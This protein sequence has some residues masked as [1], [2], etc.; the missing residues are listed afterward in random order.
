MSPPRE[1]TFLGDLLSSLTRR[2][3]AI[4]RRVRTLRFER[5]SDAID[6]SELAKVEIECDLLASRTVLRLNA[7]DDRWVWFDARRSSKTGWVWQFTAE[8]R[9]LGNQLTRELVAAFEASIGAQGSE[10]DL[11][12]IWAPILARGPRRVA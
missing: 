4:R 6:G 11:R 3:K 5:M 10:E 7:W 9:L 8:G 1:S 12:A 2:R